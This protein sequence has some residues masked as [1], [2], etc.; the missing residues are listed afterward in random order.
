MRSRHIVTLLR[1]FACLLP[2]AAAPAIAGNSYSHGGSQSDDGPAFGARLSSAQE[3]PDN[4]S[5]GVARAT[6]SFDNAFTHITV[7]VE[8]D[9]ASLDGAV[10]GVHFHCGQAGVSGPIAL[11]LVDPGPLTLDGN[12]IQG[13]LT[14][15]D[16]PAMDSCLDAVGSPVNNVASLAAAMQAG[17]IYV[18]IHTEAFPDG[19][20]RGQM[21]PGSDAA[22]G[23]IS[24][25]SRSSGHEGSTST[26]PSSSS[27]ESWLD[28][29]RNHD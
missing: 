18:N 22:G 10:T 9:L 27:W 29:Y 1:T 28:R 19:E 26:S 4:A 5:A 11:G 12:T 23:R 25:S 16:F 14:N 6:A 13:T 2:L 8:I 17:L 7:K 3:V 20:I 21:L 24:S 15:D